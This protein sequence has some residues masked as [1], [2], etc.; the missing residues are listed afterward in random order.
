[1]KRILLLFI[2]VPA[3]ALLSSCNDWVNGVQP[4]INVASNEQLNDPSQIPFVVNGVEQ[5]FSNTTAQLFSDVDLLAD[6][7]IFSFDIPT[8]AWIQ[9]QD[10]DNGT[11]T[12]DNFEAEFDNQSIGTLRLYADDLI[13]RLDKISGGDANVVKNAKFIGYFYGGLARSWAAEY[14]GFDKTNGG[15]IINNSAVMPNDQAFDLAI[16]KFKSALQYAGTD[17]EK[18]VVNTLIARCY[19]YKKDYTNAATYA[20]T[21]MVSGDAP[22][23]ALYTANDQNFMSSELGGAQRNQCALDPRFKAYL[24]ADSTEAGRISLGTTVG[25]SGTTYYLERKCTAY[26]DPIN[27][28]TWQENNL[29]LAELALRGSGSGDPL[30]LVNEVRVSHNVSA[31]TSVVL[32]NISAPNDPN[33]TSIYTERDK[34]LFTTGFRLQDE[35]RFNTWHLP[36]GSWMWIPIDLTERDRNP[37]L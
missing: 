19:L 24:D 30:T 7:F 27:V 12:L 35:H 14:L 17:Y 4:L 16:D 29:M 9:F 36:A 34:E 1:M 15:T 10:L 22:W 32:I 18:R 31:A 2:I 25:Q 3:L 8:A 5:Q 33:I 13:D 6:V 23:Q 37:N 20:S 21:G 28:V 26:S 11:I